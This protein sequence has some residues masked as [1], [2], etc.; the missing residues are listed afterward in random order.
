[1]TL[2]MLRA[3]GTPA[4]NIRKRARE[5]S[6]KRG[7]KDSVFGEKVRFVVYTT[8]REVQKKLVMGILKHVLKRVRLIIL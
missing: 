1:M 5:V 3:T 6:V 4:S 8:C 7:V 2:F